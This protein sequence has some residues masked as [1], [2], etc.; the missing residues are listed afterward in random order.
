M[1]EKVIDKNKGGLKSA[2]IFLLIRIVVYPV[3]LVGL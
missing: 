3:S 1:V 2:F